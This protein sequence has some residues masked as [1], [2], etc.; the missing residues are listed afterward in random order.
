M[1]VISLSMYQK[2]INTQPIAYSSINIP[3]MQLFCYKIS[4]MKWGGAYKLYILQRVEGQQTTLIWQ[5]III[6]LLQLKYLRL[7]SCINCYI[8]KVK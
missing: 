8:H 3:P 1:A 7:R 2:T 4:Y 5:Q 6:K